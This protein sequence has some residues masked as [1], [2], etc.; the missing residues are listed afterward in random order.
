MARWEALGPKAKANEVQWKGHA[1]EGKGY[2]VCRP[3]CLGDDIGVVHE[4]VGEHV[5][6]WV[7]VGM[8]M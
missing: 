8:R 3:P 5:G 4:G 6:V 2:C 7:W 1:D